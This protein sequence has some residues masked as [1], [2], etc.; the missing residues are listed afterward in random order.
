MRT[1]Q[2]QE[3]LRSAIQVLQRDLSHRM[4]LVE[5]T[6]AILSSLYTYIGDEEPGFLP[7]LPGETA[8]YE[9][10]GVATAA[11]EFLDSRGAAASVDEIFAALKEG[12]LRFGSTVSKKGEER[13]W[14]L[15]SLRKNTRTFQRTSDG[16]FALTLWYRR[17]KDNRPSGHTGG[18]P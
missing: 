15:E 1:N 17:K 10:K 5:Q 4:E 16:A 18:R 12:G 6:K 11:K 13:R 2:G 3:A 7:R 9:G 14:V 8:R